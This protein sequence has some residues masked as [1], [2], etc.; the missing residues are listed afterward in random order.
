MIANPEVINDRLSVNQGPTN[1]YRRLGVDVS[2]P[3]K[4][5]LAQFLASPISAPIWRFLVMF[6][7]NQHD[8]MLEKWWKNVKNDKDPWGKL[9]KYL[10]AVNNFLNGKFKLF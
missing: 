3:S 7:I 1:V 9:C 10:Q 5:S 8:P 2:D 4:I 6:E